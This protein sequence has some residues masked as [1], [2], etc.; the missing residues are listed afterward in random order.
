M[1]VGMT[2]QRNLQMPLN[3]SQLLRKNLAGIRKENDRRIKRLYHADN[4]I[5]LK[6]LLEDQKIK[7]QVKLIYIDPPYNTGGYFANRNQEFAYADKY[8]TAEYL[9][10]MKERLELMYQLL[11]DDGSIYVHL[12]SKMV[13]H[14]KLM[15]D[16]I[17]GADNF[18]GMITRKKCTS[19][20]YTKKTYGN[21]SDYILF[22]TKSDHPIWHRPYE[23][24]TTEK[25]EKEYPFIEPETGRRYKRVPIHA[26]GVRNGATGGE[27]KGM[28]PPSGKHW[29]YTPDK[30][31]EMDRNNEIYWSSTGNPRRKV[32]L[33]QS[34][35]VP[36][37]D[38][39]LDYLDIN[40]Q[41]TFQTGY[42]TEKNLEMLKRIVEA[43]SNPGDLVMD[44]FAG[45]GT[46]L[47]AAE[48]LDRDWIGVDIGDVAIQTIVDR[49]EHGSKR[50]A[51]LPVVTNKHTNPI[52][53]NSLFD[54]EDFE[55]NVGSHLPKS[56][57]YDFYE[58]I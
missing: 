22:Y 48:E 43:S 10:F 34:K 9:S 35:G 3:G 37:Q 23:Q 8:T 19:K 47:I 50:L 6:R 51:D 58:Y 20:N 5:V 7:G 45:S 21:V 42:P 46:T 28:L 36:V 30:L 32:Y 11:S 39:W 41:N 1:A 56:P 53:S 55:D 13:F 27:W 18:K 17:F 4:L 2:S 57:K 15:M 14:I 25:E 44:C 52:Q 26:P 16:D 40:N 38:I 54:N 12:D 24:W 29:Q 49:L 33:D 31:D